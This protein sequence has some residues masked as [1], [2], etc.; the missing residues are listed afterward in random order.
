MKNEEKS[1]PARKA[2]RD[3]S[4]NHGGGRSSRF[5]ATAKKKDKEL[6]RP[7][8]EQEE[9]KEEDRNDDAL[10][11]LLLV[12]SDLSALVNQI[13][14][15]VVEAFKCKA[16]SSKEVESFTHFLSD[17]HSSLKPWVPR[18][19]KALSTPVETAVVNGVESVEPK[20]PEVERKDIES[21]EQSDLESLISP[22]PLVSWR[23]DCTIQ[24]G[25]QLFML[26]PLPIS[27]SL[28]SKPPM[29]S[30][31]LVF[32]RVTS[33]TTDGLPFFDT[34]SGDT[35]DALPEFVAIEPTP[36]KPSDSV[37]TE[38]EGI[39]E[40]G[41]VSPPMSKRGGSILLNL[42]TPCLKSPPKSCVLLE[43]IPESSPKGHH[44]VCNRKSTPYPVGIRNSS[45]SSSS[46]TSEDEDVESSPDWCMSP[47]KTCVVLQPPDENSSDKAGHLR[48]TRL[49][50]PLLK[51]NEGVGG[52]PQIKTEL[53]GDGRF[54]MIESTP[55]W[56]Q[57]G[58]VVVHKTKH[59]GENT[60][61]RELWIKFEAASTNELSFDDSVT[62]KRLLDLLDEASS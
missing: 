10:D 42:M 1:R 34:T 17:M 20:S 43:P 58:S 59:P 61:K 54:A 23:A 9:R 8:V 27:K 33:N 21:P 19:Q 3:V 39:V 6:Q 35:N 55:I 36:S 26:T 50:W 4:N 56:K 22:S 15:L 31:T 12:Q 48:D 13:D 29:S 46:E 24:R 53:V 30:K 47:P 44:R 7:T 40:S 11:R 16:G 5:S 32:E 14:Q 38:T 45:D 49:N 25:R 2:L 60:L 62:Q 41:F 51:E 57:A 18:F 37:A 52:I 28:S